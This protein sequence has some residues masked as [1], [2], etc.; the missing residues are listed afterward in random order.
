MHPGFTSKTNL[1]IAFQF[2]PPLSLSHTHTISH[3]KL[4]VHQIHLPNSSNAKTFSIDH[5]I[6]NFPPYLIAPCLP[7]SYSSIYTITTMAFKIPQVL[8]ILLW[9]SLILLLF[10][11]FYILRFK[12]NKKEKIQA[13]FLL[14]S[15]EPLLSRKILAT[16]FDFSPFIKHPHKQSQGM[17]VRLDPSGTKIDPRYG[18][19][20]RRVPTGPNPLHH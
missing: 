3:L 15:H 1:L 8:L 18:V 13:S 16:N 9:L 10:H 2:Q 12:I 6:L 4:C 20:K 14:P 11:E 7:F 19:E 5:S 17:K